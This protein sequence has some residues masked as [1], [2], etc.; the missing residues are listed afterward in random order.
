MLEMGG[1][2]GGGM[3]PLKASERQD[4]LHVHLCNYWSHVTRTKISCKSNNV[5]RTIF[6]G[7]RN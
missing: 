7:I 3:E 1:G 6:H 5:T 4:A 2:G